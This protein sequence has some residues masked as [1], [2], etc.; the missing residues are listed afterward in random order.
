MIEALSEDDLLRPGQSGEYHFHAV[1]TGDAAATVRFVF[2][3]QLPGW[4]GRIIHVDEAL[5]GD[6]VLIAP[7]QS[8][9]VVVAV[10]APRDAR[11]GDRNT[12]TVQAELVAAA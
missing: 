10:A 11:L 12:T 8:V 3:N 7:G 4:T 2:A 6:P 5:P 9:R 1:N